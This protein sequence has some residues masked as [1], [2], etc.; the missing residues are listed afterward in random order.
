MPQSDAERWNTRYQNDARY[1]RD[2]GPREF[3]L[4]C[5]PYLP[6]C[7]L[8]LDAATGLGGNAGYLSKRGLQVIG[9]DISR[10]A[11]RRARMRY[12]ALWLVQ[13]DLCHFPLPANRFDL[14]INFYYLERSVWRD[15][16]R[17]LRPGG[18]LVVET[19]TREMRQIQPDIPEEYLLAPGELRELFSGLKVL[20]YREEWIEG[21]GSHPRPIASLLA[22]KV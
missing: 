5:E 22:V 19:L 8:A 4:S 20:H 11:L 14:I 18:V 3:L 1:H 6:T 16:P 12:P 7:G 15:F 10:V 13:A 2:P 17:A 9:V 21:S